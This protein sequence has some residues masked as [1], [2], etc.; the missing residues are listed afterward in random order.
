MQKWLLL[1]CCFIGL[2]STVLT[3]TRETTEAIEAEI[4]RQREAIREKRRREAIPLV[5]EK[6][7]Q[8]FDRVIV[9]FLVPEDGT[10]SICSHNPLFVSLTFYRPLLYFYVARHFT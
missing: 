6:K 3:L 9:T 1:L 2:W 10:A 5:D 7:Y 8:Q 4:E